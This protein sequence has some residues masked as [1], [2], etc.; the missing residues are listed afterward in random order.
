MSKSVQDRVWVEGRGGLCW[1]V[2]SE[3]TEAK[4]EK[5]VGGERERMGVSDWLTV[6]DRERGGDRKWE[7]MGKKVRVRVCESEGDRMREIEWD[8]IFYVLFFLC[9]HWIIFHAVRMRFLKTFWHSAENKNTGKNY[10]KKGDTV[11]KY[12]MWK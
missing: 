3:G 7:K 12:K 8:S 1:V 5:R 10:I 9:Y 4:R 11:D 2:V 6:C